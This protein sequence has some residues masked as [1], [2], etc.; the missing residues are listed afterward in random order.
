MWNWRIPAD[1]HIKPRVRILR[2]R[3]QCMNQPTWKSSEP[4]H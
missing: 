1:F 4:A 3:F 2:Y